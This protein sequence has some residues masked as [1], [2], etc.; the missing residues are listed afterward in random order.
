MTAGDG[1]NDVLVSVIVDAGT[2][3]GGGIDAVTEMVDTVPPKSC[4]IDTVYSTVSLCV[5]TCNTY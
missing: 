4:A 3:T 1:T 5:I 2:V